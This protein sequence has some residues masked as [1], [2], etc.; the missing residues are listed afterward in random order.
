MKF[1][2]STSNE[3]AFGLIDCA[4]NSRPC[5]LTETLD[6]TLNE[7]EL[8]KNVD[9]ILLFMSW[10]SPASG[11]YI[12]L[13]EYQ[14]VLASALA[15]QHTYPIRECQESSIGCQ[16]MLGKV[17]GC[18]ESARRVLGIIH[19]MLGECQELLGRVH[20]IL[21]ECY[22]VIDSLLKYINSVVNCQNSHP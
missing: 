16:L 6:W 15:S 8:Q 20:R 14:I 19:R 12:W 11:K 3:W 22:V 5:Y 1:C 10:V 7:S 17:H 13:A 4:G 2:I 21:A 9:I 18:Q